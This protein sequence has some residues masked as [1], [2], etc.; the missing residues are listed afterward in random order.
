MPNNC[1]IRRAAMAGRFTWLDRMEGESVRAYDKRINDLAAFHSGYAFLSYENYCPEFYAFAVYTVWN[2]EFNRKLVNPLPEGGFMMHC[3]ARRAE[4]MLSCAHG[5]PV[6]VKLCAKLGKLYVESFAMADKDVVFDLYFNGC[7]VKAPEGLV[8]MGNEAPELLPVQKGFSVAG[9]SALP[10]YHGSHR[11]GSYIKAG[12]VP[13][14]YIKGS[15]YRAGAAAG[16]YI[17]GSFYRLGTASGSYM[18][19]SY[20]RWGAASGSYRGGLS[21][22]Y[23]SWFFGGGSYLKLLFGAGSYRSRL[24]GGGYTGGFSAGSFT[25]SSFTAGFYYGSSY[26]GGSYIKGSFAGRNFIGGSYI[27]GSFVSGRF[28]G[29]GVGGRYFMTGSFYNGSYHRG[30]FIY[31]GF[32]DVLVG[33]A[34]PPA[35]NKAAENDKNH[36]EEFVI[37]RLIEELG[38]GL[39]LI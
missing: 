24:Y 13:G 32:A 5:F 9:G 35:E 26:V 18:T 4:E 1:N 3:D 22:S 12:S 2:H 28:E 36:H 34:Q 16:S 10:R 29:S 20:Y 25:G 15:Y 19:G 11:R 17:K 38:Y 8:F 31:G 14:S 27:G 23:L 6:F 21:G 7:D 30:S 37:R 39:D 33:S